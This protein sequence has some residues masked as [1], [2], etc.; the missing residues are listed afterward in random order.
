MKEKLWCRLFGHDFRVIRHEEDGYVYTKRS[1]WC[2]YC[3]LTKRE[4]K[5]KRG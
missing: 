2:R 4:L 5:Q 1:D 3:G